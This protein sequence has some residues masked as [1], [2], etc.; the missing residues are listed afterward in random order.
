MS[1]IHPDNPACFPDRIQAVCR[2]D[3]ARTGDQ[4]INRLLDLFLRLCIQCTDR[5]IQLDKLFIPQNRRQ[6]QYA[7]AVCPTSPPPSR[8]M[9]FWSSGGRLHKFLQSGMTN[10]F[11]HLF[12]R[13]IRNAENQII[14]ERSGKENGI[15][16]DNGHIMAKIIYIPFR[17][18]D[19]VNEDLTFH[20]QIKPQDQ[21]E[22]CFFRSR[23][24]RQKQPLRLPGYGYLHYPVLWHR[25][26]S[27][28]SLT[29][30]HRCV[31]SASSW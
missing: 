22:Q 3:H 24:R 15:P 19:S 30:Q 20:G 21:I 2:H 11:T 25:C 17:K 16:G 8:I 5:L 13:H 18:R 26:F 9:P 4:D 31:E 1:L 6:W 10:H 12:C 14:P 29:N 23:I 28:H 7:A 27:M